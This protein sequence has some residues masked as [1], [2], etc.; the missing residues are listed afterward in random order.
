MHLRVWSLL[1]HGF[2]Y[3]YHSL[4]ELSNGKIAHVDFVELHT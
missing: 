2:R 4:R 3:M 1:N